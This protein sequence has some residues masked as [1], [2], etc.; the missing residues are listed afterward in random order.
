[1][2][3]TALTNANWQPRQGN[4]PYTKG[5]R[6]PH[7]RADVHPAARIILA[8][9]CL[10]PLRWKRAACA[11]AAPRGRAPSALPHR[12]VRAGRNLRI[13][14]GAEGRHRSG[15][16]ARLPGVHRGRPGP[17]RPGE[18]PRGFVLRIDGVVRALAHRRHRHG[19]PRLASRSGRFRAV[20]EVLP[21]QPDRGRGLAA[22]G[23]KR[24]GLRPHREPRHH[25]GANQGPGPTRPARRRLRHA[26]SRATQSA[27]VRHPAVRRGEGGR[28]VQRGIELFSKGGPA[29]ARR[30]LDRGAGGGF[31]RP[32]SSC[33]SESFCW[34]CAAVL[35]ATGGTQRGRAQGGGAG[36]RPAARIAWPPRAP[37]RPGA[38]RDRRGAQQG[39][40]AAAN[41]RARSSDDRRLGRPAEGAEGVYLTE[42]FAVPI[43]GSSDPA[44]EVAR[45]IERER[46][47]RGLPPLQRDAALDRVADSEIHA[48]ALADQMKLD[49]TLTK[50]A[51]RES[52]DLSSAVAELHVGSAPE[53]LGWS[54]NLTAREWTH[55]GVG[56]LYA[57]SRQYGPG[58]LWV[59]LLYGR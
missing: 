28:V 22:P 57:S 3:P 1:M 39:D 7:Q 20:P 11:A 14:P 47:K 33:N 32:S 18:R 26:G 21:V 46:S 48:T 53:E 43:V 54:K 35:A 24:G 15:S 13:V 37:A 9:P 29:G 59:L 23:R 16:D 4:L 5:E 51:L 25:A 17:A 45:F 6:Q 58:R 30:A 19:Q 52:R 31:R 41:V 10:V 36:D 44:G 49:Q 42:V 12:G 8:R 40:G 50:R 55:I 56:A 2:P 34:S 38:G 27:A